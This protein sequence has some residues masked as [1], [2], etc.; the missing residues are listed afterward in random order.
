MFDT[1]ELFRIFFAG[2]PLL[3][4]F[5][6]AGVVLLILHRSRALQPG[7]ER[8]VFRILCATGTLALAVYAI[9]VVAYARD[10][11]FYDYAEPTMTAVSWLFT[12]G[13][14]IYPEID[15]AERYAHIYGPMAFIPHGV[16]LRVFGPSIL[17]SKWFGA[18]LALTSMT[19]LYLALRARITTAWALA[20]TGGC[21]C[22]YLIFRNLTFWTRPDSLQLLCVCAGLY[23]TARGP[24]GAALIVGSTTGVLLNLKIT[25]P[26][27]SLPILALLFARHGSRA[28][29]VAG[30]SGVAVAVFPF[31]AFANVSLESYLN[32]VRFSAGN[33]LVLATLR[34]NIEWA[35]FFLTP[36]LLSFH[37]LARNAR[38]STREDRL[39]LAGL[40]AGVC[41]TVLAASKPGATYYHLV[42]F[43]PVIFYLTAS[44]LVPLVANRAHC[45]RMTLACAIGF[46]GTAVALAGA[47]Q[48]AF[49]RALL[50]RSGAQELDDL[51]M[52]ARAHPKAIVEMG[53]GSDDRLILARP[54]LVFRSG[55]YLLDPP[56][57]QEHQLSG[58]EIPPA[59]I[60]A[61]RACRVDYWLIP[62]GQE[63]FSGP[64]RYPAMRLKPLFPASFRQA[65]FDSYEPKARTQ[66]YEAWRCRSDGPR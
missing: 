16:A 45:D 7:T 27:Y 51:R 11:H 59:T 3:L 50:D 49:Q 53:Y 6:L 14:P 63:P 41:G 12:V 61:I 56:A 35:L 36:A 31:I 8:W 55:V 57:I 47:H 15:A 32:W 37:T 66:Y 29:I 23:A 62:L 43:L 20:L 64:N 44:Y 5:A 33:G 21:A 28:T 22:L 42:P 38:S 17:V 4:S 48:T 46:A 60:D 25:G 10:P 54:E 9:V 34:T 24:F 19:L 30:I 39:L 1:L 13:R 65:F 2:R 58:L 40:V 52:F 26:L 18:G